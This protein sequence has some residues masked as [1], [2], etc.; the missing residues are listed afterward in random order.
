MQ[1][2]KKV[3]IKEVCKILELP[4]DSWTLNPGMPIKQA[5]KCIKQFKELVKKQR[6]ILA[7]NYHPDK[8]GG[9]DT[10]IKQINNIVDVVDKLEIQPVRQP[11]MTV[12]FSNFSGVSDSTSTTGSFYGYKFDAWGV[13]K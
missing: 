7:K 9:D 5:V 12:H 6:K 8:T 2:Q 10:K 3:S 1:P 13:M 11:T 4:I